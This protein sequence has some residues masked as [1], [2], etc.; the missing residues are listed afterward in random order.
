MKL[1]GKNFQPWAD[2][3]FEI[4]KLTVLVGPSNKGKSSLFRALKGVLRN[5]IDAD[6]IR[7]P[8]KEPLELVLDFNGTTIK[9]TRNKQGKVKYVINGDEKNAYTSL[10]GIV[11]PP[12][13]DLQCGEITVGEFTFDPIFGRQNEPQFLL[14]RKAY[15]PSDLNAIL[16]AFGGTER[17]EQGKKEAG[18]R[19][20]DKNAE[21]KTLA[22]EI[23]NAEE[24][25]MKLTD[26]S[27]IGAAVTSN[28]QELELRIRL[29][30][31]KQVW[32]GE[33]RSRRARLK[34][35]ETLQ[36]ALVLPNTAQ[37]EL[38]TQQVAYLTQAAE[39]K[40]LSKWLGKVVKVVDGGS[41][42]WNAIL[43]IWRKLAAVGVLQQALTDHKE[44]PE[45]GDAEPQYSA[46]RGLLSSIRLIGQVLEVR[47]SL[48]TKAAELT[49]IDSEL[50]QAQEEL[51]KGLCPKCGKGMEHD[52]GA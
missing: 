16:G 1:T 31:F 20:S 14:D 13:K 22:E 15:K 3:D 26:L 52:C 50:T 40:V 4:D 51:K 12:V 44:F 47:R 25:K 36:N 45:I 24:R 23:R 11:P 9:A 46:C 42:A 19:V 38:L 7:D 10:A 17:L 37:A 27:G 34:P 39:S 48:K 18:S 30:D 41:E 33:A 6:Y 35:L 28:L 29:L 5:E 32:I 49:Q 8:K 2:F 43:P 21:A